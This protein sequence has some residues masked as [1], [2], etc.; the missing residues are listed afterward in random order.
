[1]MMATIGKARRQTETSLRRRLR[2]FLMLAAIL[3][4]A[5]INLSAEAQERVPCNARDVLADELKTDHA[6][7]PIGLG[8]TDAGKVI[9]LWKSTDGAT[10]TLLLTMPNGNSCIVG[11][12]KDWMTANTNPMAKNF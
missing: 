5:G 2:H 7:K 6:E 11:A 10:W 9:E 8:V 4:P 3:L 1:M 12:G